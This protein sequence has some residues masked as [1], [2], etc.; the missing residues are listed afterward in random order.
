MTSSALQASG[1]SRR[2]ARAEAAAWI[3]RLHGPHRTP[4]L[5]AGFRAWLAADPQN[6]REFER[7]TEVWD[8]G[9][10]PVSGLPR[11]TASRESQPQL[12]W[13]LAAMVLLVC[14]IS[15]W[16]LSTF[17]FNPSY[18]TR[19]AEQ[20]LVRLDDGSRITLNS[21]TR[22]RVTYRPAERRVRLERGEAYFEVAHDTRPF[23]VVA[24]DHHVTALGT[25][26]VVRHDVGQTAVTLVEGKIAVSPPPE[27]LA[28][29]GSAA[30]T[31]RSG[32]SADTVQDHVE[33]PQLPASIVM[34]PGQRLTFTG[35]ARPRLDQPRVEAVTAW[36]RG[37]VMLDDTTL[38]DAVAEMNRY[39]EAVLVI[40]EPGVAGLRI[41]GI[42]HAGNSEGFAHTV[43]D[44]YGLRVLHE[45]GRIH[46]RR[47]N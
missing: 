42:Y 31:H 47:A 37:E 33:V 25:S 21:N 12:R 35:G 40:D 11:V 9:S 36:R 41:S 4:E 26:F 27:D 19:L 39:D 13:A 20:R 28:G 22:L 3:V 18:A 1:S 17:W 16:A 24:G 29:V 34:T 43:A 45:R 7:V 32:T 23:V 30:R 46:L 15:A 2:A 10:V 8:T 14:G 38:A 44:L 6:G 5:E